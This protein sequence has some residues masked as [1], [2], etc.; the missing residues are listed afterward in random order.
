MILL[1]A[2]YFRVLPLLFYVNECKHVYKIFHGFLPYL[3]SLNLCFHELLSSS[4]GYFTLYSSLNFVIEKRLITV[5]KFP[6]LVCESYLFH[7]VESFSTNS[8]KLSSTTIDQAVLSPIICIPNCLPLHLLQLK[9]PC[10]VLTLI[11]C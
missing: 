11:K 4:T 10:L 7:K 5:A 6:N 8:T 2:Y 9:L 1:V 3:F